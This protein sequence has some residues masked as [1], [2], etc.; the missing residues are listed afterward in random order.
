VKISFRIVF[1]R[2][3]KLRCIDSGPLEQFLKRR[4]QHLTE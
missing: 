2:W 1:M 3:L 4:L